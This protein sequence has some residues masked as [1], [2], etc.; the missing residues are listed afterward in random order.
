VQKLI[1]LAK[2]IKWGIG[3]GVV[4]AGIFSVWAGFVYVVNGTTAVQKYHASLLAVIG[5]YVACGVFGGVILGVLRPV[6]HTKV[7]NAVTGFAIGV[8]CGPC[9]RIAL[10][11]I[12]QW[13]LGD[14]G[15]LLYTGIFGTV[16]AIATYKRGHAQG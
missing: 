4:I 12:S 14:V 11:G 7:G 9:F 3:Y 1:L 5:A 15:W 10:D 16:C 13:T 6:S 2:N 8:A